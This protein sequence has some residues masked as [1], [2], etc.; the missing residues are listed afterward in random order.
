VL[1]VV[2]TLATLLPG[3]RGAQAATSVPGVPQSVTSFPVVVVGRDF[4]GGLV[5]WIR[6]SMI[7]AGKIAPGD[8]DLIHLVD[9]PDEAVAIMGKPG[10]R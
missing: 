8:L 2:A 9:D 1:I 10:D 6:D 3:F 5:D 4:W 7:P